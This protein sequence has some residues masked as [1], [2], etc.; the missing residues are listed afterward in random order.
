MKIFIILIVVAL[1]SNFSF[2]QQESIDKKTDAFHLVDLALENTVALKEK[3]TLEYEFYQDARVDSFAC[4]Y[5]YSKY[6]ASH[7]EV[8]KFRTILELLNSMEDIYKLMNKETG[9]ETP[10]LFISKP[11]TSKA[12]LEITIGGNDYRHITLTLNSGAKMF[13]TSNW[14]NTSLKNDWQIGFFAPYYVYDVSVVK[15][16]KSDELLYVSIH[17]QNG[18]KTCSNSDLYMKSVKSNWNVNKSTIK[19]DTEATKR[20]QRL[21]EIFEGEIH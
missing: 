15:V 1:S 13:Y 17:T 21:K 12:S 10:L 8:F 19:E 14:I 18:E 6:L 11:S 4:M 16:K 20:Y 3:L 2:S 9:F 5:W 7:P